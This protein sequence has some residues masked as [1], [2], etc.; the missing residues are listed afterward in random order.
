MCRWST[1]R[2]VDEWRL[3]VA[4][5]ELQG[6]LV[7]ADNYV[8]MIAATLGVSPEVATSIAARYPLS[9]YPSPA[10]AL[11]AV[12]TDAIFACPALTV[13]KTLS[14][15][16]PTYGYEF[17]DRDAP[18]LLPPVSFPQGA[19][20]AT[21]LQYLFRLPIGGTLSPDQQRL[22]LTMRRLWTGF[23]ATGTPSWP[24]FNPARQPLLSL[25]SPRPVVATDFA[26]T[27]QCGFWSAVTP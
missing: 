21:E 13:N 14:R 20:H 9:A 16:V 18:A 4:L 19:A 24:R 10:E 2:P 5:G 15:F 12:G 25:V 7:T 1:G 3:F 23:A 11:G 17:N 22:A 8:E 6:V 26:T 27:H